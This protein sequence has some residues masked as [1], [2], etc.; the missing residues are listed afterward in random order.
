MAAR[1]PLKIQRM[2]SALSLVPFSTAC[3]AL[4]RE[5]GLG[6]YDFAADLRSVWATASNDE[7]ELRVQARLTSSTHFKDN[8][9]PGDYACLFG[10]T[11][12]ARGGDFSIEGFDAF[13]RGTLQT[14]RL[15]SYAAR[16]ANV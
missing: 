2:F 5:Y 4:Q 14:D 3:R 15:H 6:E 1:K 7:I 11:L 9:P 8:I 13:L 16:R 12:L 10:V